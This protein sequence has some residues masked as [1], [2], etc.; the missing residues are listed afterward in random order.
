M[1][2]VEKVKNMLDFGPWHPGADAERYRISIGITTFDARFGQYFIPLLSKIR[3]YDS[4]LEVIVAIN[5][6]HNRD[7]DESYR[8]RMLAFLASQK[9]VFP[10]VFPRF[11]SLTKLWNS[12]VIHATHEYVLMLNDDI[13]ITNPCFVRDLQAAI[14]KNQGRSLLINKSWS[15]FL[16]SR[17]EIDELGYFDERLL[18]IGEED[19]DMIWRYIQRYD[20]TMANIKMKGFVNYS[21]QTNDYRPGN[22]KNREG[23]KYSLFNRQ[24]MFSTKYAADQH[25]IQGMFEE[26]VAMKDEGKEQYPYER[27]YRKNKDSL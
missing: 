7:F 13:M 19:G 17:Q 9:R 22:I 18:G 1:S 26:P 20:R 12:I 21:G 8:E 6:E 4:D 24:F 25:G 23:M 10:I 15:H 27:F 14:G 2:I 16:I 3:G 5:G 11:R